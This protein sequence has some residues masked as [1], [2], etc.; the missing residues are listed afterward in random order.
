MAIPANEKQPAARTITAVCYESGQIVCRVL[1]G[2]F[3]LGVLVVPVPP[4]LLA[5][6]IVISDDQEDESWR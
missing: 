6:C 4:E 2:P 5:R 1:T 3:R